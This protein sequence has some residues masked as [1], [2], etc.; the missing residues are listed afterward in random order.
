MKT[1]L[2]ISLLLL[3]ATFECVKKQEKTVHKVVYIEKVA[4]AVPKPLSQY[5]QCKRECRI[6]RDAQSNAERVEQL[7]KEIDEAEALLAEHNKHVDAPEIPEERQEGSGD[8]T[9]KQASRFDHLKRAASRIVDS[10]SEL[11]N[12]ITGGGDN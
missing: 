11:K 5:E 8:N 12:A 3:L 9:A 2:L 6:Q 1:F 7:K 4:P 10:G